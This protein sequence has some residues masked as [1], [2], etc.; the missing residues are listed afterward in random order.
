MKW[1]DYE[2]EIEDY[3]LP[4]ARTF[5]RLLLYGVIKSIHS[6]LLG[7]ITS[8]G[9]SRVDIPFGLMIKVTYYSWMFHT[10]MHQTNAQIVRY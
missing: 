6:L 9:G 4:H 10:T 3:L 8:H 5:D 7:E 2:K 1:V